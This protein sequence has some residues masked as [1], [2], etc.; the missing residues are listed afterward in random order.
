MNKLALHIVYMKSL[1]NRNSRFSSLRLQLIKCLKVSEND[2]SR[3]FA[4]LSIEN[5]LG[6]NFFKWNWINEL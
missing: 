1:S 6:N 3:E 4:S 2:V 5:L